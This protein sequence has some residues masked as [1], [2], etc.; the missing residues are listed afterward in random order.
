MRDTQSQ[1]FEKLD[2]NAT[3]E[4]LDTSAFASI[5]TEQSSNDIIKSL[6][7]SG[8]AQTES[9]FGDDDFLSI[10]ALPGFESPAT[11]KTETAVARAEDIDLTQVGDPDKKSKDTSLFAEY[12]PIGI[13][14]DI[15]NTMYGVYDFWTGTSKKVTEPFNK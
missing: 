15:A 13:F 4:T 7:S 5:L 11:A 10:P 3:S 6:R 1:A 9:T 8:T 12:A 2:S 14:G